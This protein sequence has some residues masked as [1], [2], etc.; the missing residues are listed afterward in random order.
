MVSAVLAA[1]ALA[2]L[3]IVAFLPWS[4]ALR[5]SIGVAVATLALH[6]HRGL[7]EVRSFVVRGGGTIAVVFHDGRTVEGTLRPGCFVAPWLTLVRWRPPRA[8]FDRTIL[9]TAGRAHP[10]AFRRLRVRLR[11][12]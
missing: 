8:R 5:A 12:G 2:T 9:V 3:V 7:H 11:Q 10:E 4:M 1:A 6:G